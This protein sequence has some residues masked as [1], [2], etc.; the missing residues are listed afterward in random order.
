MS[1]RTTKIHPELTLTPVRQLRKKRPSFSPVKLLASEPKARSMSGTNSI[2]PVVQNTREM[3][4]TTSLNFQEFSFWD[5]QSKQ[6]GNISTE[7]RAALM[8][9]MRTTYNVGTMDICFPFLILYCEDSVPGPDSRPFM[10][11]G[12]IGVWLEEGDDFPLELFPGNLSGQVLTS[13]IEI[14]EHL[15]SD[16]KPY[17]I[18]KK[19]TLLALASQYFP[20]ATHISYMS[21]QLVVELPKQSVD[22]YSKSLEHLPGTISNC[23]LRLVYHN[24]PQTITELKRS[25]QP[26]PKYLDGVYDDVDYVKERGSFFP[27]TMLSSGEEN[28][29]SAGILVSKGNQNRVTIAFHCW[30]EEYT[31]SADKLGDSA[32]FKVTQG[33]LKAGTNVGYVDERIGTTDIGLCKLLPDIT[34]ENRFLELD[35]TAKT[36]LHSSDIEFGDVFQ[37]DSF[38]TGLQQL[39]CLGIRVRTEGGR[40]EQLIGK[41]EILPQHGVYVAVVQGIY[42]TSAPEIYGKPQMR[43]G[44]CGSALVRALKANGKESVLS[45]GGIGGFMHWSDLRAKSLESTLLCYCDVLDDL[46][47]AGWNMTPI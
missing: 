18:P 38:V 6:M 14:D 34:F 23:G 10:I 7:L 5:N 2:K 30:R 11:A 44:V 21:N 33:S 17:R 47:D 19:Q 46:I 41:K 35:V 43:E 26:N 45:D 40:E 15:A 36:L 32:Y 37:I 20:N 8:K 16:L 29:I 12:C 1:T 28:C 31:Q 9:Y 27:G 42:A 4:L 24:G 22:D 13:N 25:K 3:A 39:K